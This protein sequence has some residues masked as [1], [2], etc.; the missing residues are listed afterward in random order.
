MQPMF[1]GPD[2]L[3]DH[4]F[5]EAMPSGR[6]SATRTDDLS[7][8]ASRANRSQG[9]GANR[10]DHDDSVSGRDDDEP[11]IAPG[12]Q[13]SSFPELMNIGQ[14]EFRDSRSSS[15]PV[16]TSSIAFQVLGNPEPGTSS[17]VAFDVHLPIESGGLDWRASWPNDGNIFGMDFAA[18]MPGP[19]APSSFPQFQ[20]P[21][22]AAG[23]DEFMLPLSIENLN[24]DVASRNVRPRPSV[25]PTMRNMSPP[26]G[27]S[28]FES[29]R[30]R[31]I[32]DR[33]D[34]HPSPTPSKRSRSN[35]TGSHR[36]RGMD[37]ET[38]HRGN[39]SARDSGRGR[40]GDPAS[41]I[42]RDPLNADTL[43]NVLDGIE[44]FQEEFNRSSGMNAQGVHPTPNAAS[45]FAL[46]DMDGAN[47]PIESE[48][49]MASSSSR[50]HTISNATDIESMSESRV[51]NATDLNDIVIADSCC[52]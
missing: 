36:A 17:G 41:I 11:G 5:S 30:E 21:K 50:N 20:S 7:S 19:P 4:T 45:I 27:L 31:N 40:S 1:S 22:R 42:G 23:S 3:S 38:A 39:P 35:S 28:G 6:S 52:S 44:A 24:P 32:V 48:S 46:D 12:A 14:S 18:W 25:N 26:P 15:R 8:S 16:P 43:V 29:P 2:F 13:S 9:H 37:R 51:S 10:P 47:V 49:M 34:L 33:L